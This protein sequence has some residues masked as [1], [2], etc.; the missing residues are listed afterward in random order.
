MHPADRKRSRRSRPRRTAPGGRLDDARSTSPHGLGPGWADPH[1]PLARILHASSCV[2]RGNFQFEA[3]DSPQF[4]ADS[5]LPGRDPAVASRTVHVH[6]VLMLAATALIALFVLIVVGVTT[7]QRR[8]RLG[9]PDR[10]LEFGAYG[11][12]LA[13]ACSGGAAAVHIAVV[14]EHAA[15]T[16]ASTSP[17]A[18]A[19]LCSIGAGSTHF[20]GSA[21]SVAGFL[22]LGILSLGVIGAQGTL[23]V[24]RIW[25]SRRLVLAGLGIT[26]VALAV[27]LLTRLMAPS[28]AGTQQV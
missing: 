19:L 7:L 15:L 23:A 26:I 27:A 4:G 11:P 6:V 16:A 18:V 24:P 25:R 12:I 21:T 20:T 9:P 2:S 1:C 14:G 8:G 17:D 10:R 13:A 5:R 3:R 22:P 28:G